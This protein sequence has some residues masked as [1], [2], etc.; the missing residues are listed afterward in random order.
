MMPRRTIVMDEYA[1]R[2]IQLMCD[3]FAGHVKG[4]HPASYSR[5]VNALI[6]HV[7]AGMKKDELLEF[8]DKPEL[9]AQTIKRAVERPFE[10]E[11]HTLGSF[12]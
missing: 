7:I 12:P 1:D 10:N 8:V 6:A 2:F 5:V 4:Y 11:H 3:F 9:I